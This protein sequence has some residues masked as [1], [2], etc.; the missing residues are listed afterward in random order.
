MLKFNVKVT[1][2]NE[3]RNKLGAKAAQ[4]LEAA[5]DLDIGVETRKM[6]N[7]AAD[8]APIET[9]ALKASFRYSTRRDGSMSWHFGSYLPY[10]LR[11]EYEHIP[12][13]GYSRT[14][15]WDGIPETAKTIR[16]TLK[17]RLGG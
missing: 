8:R 7:T 5:L 14:A 17:K 9:G 15:Y 16:A 3:V 10:A 6:A 11:Q 12:K 13:A 2:I 4:G 1:G